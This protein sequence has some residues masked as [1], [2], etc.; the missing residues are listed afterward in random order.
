[1]KKNNNRMSRDNYKIYC[2]QCRDWGNI[3]PIT[4]VIP[5]KRFKKPKYKKWED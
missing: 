4:K 2:S 5:D 1:M 3:N